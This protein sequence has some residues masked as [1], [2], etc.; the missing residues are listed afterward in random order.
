MKQQATTSA[1]AAPAEFRLLLSSTR[2]GARLARTLAVQ[3]LNDW[4]DVPHGSETAHAVAVVTAE[5]ASNAVAH[6]CLPGRNFR[7][8]LRLLPHVFRVEVADTRPD[9]APSLTVPPSAD[10]TS[11]RG[12]LLVAAHAGR[13]G[14]T[15][16]DAYAKTVWAEV[17]LPSV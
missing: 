1:P 2:R 8:T 15:V 4:C 12:L 6:G 14:C 13:W 11:G 9:A 17:R 7:L 16:H 5:L 3:Q 10:G